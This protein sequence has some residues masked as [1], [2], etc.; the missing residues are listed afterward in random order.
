MLIWK[1]E[2]ICRKVGQSRCLTKV[3]LI[4]RISGGVPSAV[5]CPALRMHIRRHAMHCSIEPNP[6]AEPAPLLSFWTLQACSTFLEF[7][8]EKPTRSTRSWRLACTMSDLIQTR[9]TSLLI[10]T[11]QIEAALQASASQSRIG[12]QSDGPFAIQDAWLHAVEHR[13]SGSMSLSV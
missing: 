11:C 9:P 12:I 13:S 7:V 3:M 6:E 5:G 10:I 4:L 2:G 1:P 8:V